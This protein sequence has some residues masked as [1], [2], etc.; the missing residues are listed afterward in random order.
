M[1][2]YSTVPVIEKG[3]LLLGCS[4]L[5]ARPDKRSMGHAEVLW[6]IWKCHKDFLCPVVEKKLAQKRTM[7]LVQHDITWNQAWGSLWRSYYVWIMGDE[8][9]QW[10]S[11]KTFFWCFLWMW[12]SFTLL[13]FMSYVSAVKHIGS[14]SFLYFCELTWWSVGTHKQSSKTPI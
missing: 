3:R 14:P 10:N 11:Q 7:P 6:C 5:V 4:T 13:G 9:F 12:W 8:G 1:H 2:S